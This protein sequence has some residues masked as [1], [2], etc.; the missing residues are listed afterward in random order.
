MMKRIESQ[1]VSNGHTGT[2]GDSVKTLLTLEETAVRTHLTEKSL[3]M[4]IF[5]GQF[6]VT[7]IGK[8]IFVAE[9]QLEKFLELST[10]TAEE[11]NAK[12]RDV[13]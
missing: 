5:R 1:E 11:A 8:R 7:R 4:R 6:P 13:A 10:V 3:R 2:K 12:L 9:D